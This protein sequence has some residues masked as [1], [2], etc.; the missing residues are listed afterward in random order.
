VRR[1]VRAL[2]ADSPRAFEVYLKYEVFSKVFREKIASGQTLRWSTADSTKLTSNRTE[3][4]AA[5]EV[6]ADGPRPTRGWSA[7]PWRTV[8]GVLADSRLGATG[9]SDNH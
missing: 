1:I 5:R 2:G 8:C 9:N 3:W 7:R 6:R 4:C